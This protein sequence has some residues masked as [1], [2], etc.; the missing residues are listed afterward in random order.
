MIPPAGGGID[1]VVNIILALKSDL[2]VG[3][4]RNSHNEVDTSEVEPPQ[5]WL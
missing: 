1:S 4:V 2:S 3:W 5:R